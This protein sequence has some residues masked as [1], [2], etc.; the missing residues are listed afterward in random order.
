MYSFGVFI[1]LDGSYGKWVED[2]VAG[3]AKF[4]LGVGWRGA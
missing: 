1:G 4:E 2:M 3:V